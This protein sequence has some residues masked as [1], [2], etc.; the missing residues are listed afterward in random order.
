MVEQL[1]L[2]RFNVAQYHEMKR[3]GILPP[4]ARVEL[5]DGMVTDM[6]RRTQRELEVIARLAEVL[7]EK[8][9]AGAT[10]DAPPPAHPEAYATFDP[11][12]MVHDWA[13]LPL[14]APFPLHRFSIAEYH[15]MIEVEIVPLSVLTEL[16]DGVVFDTRSE[17]PHV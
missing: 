4:Q 16:I 17:E 6:R 13:A 3:L 14:T 8:L 9:G 2:R 7:A 5:L 10:I 15:R 11:T 12:L 1:R